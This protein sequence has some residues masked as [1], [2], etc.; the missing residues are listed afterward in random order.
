M[1][2]GKEIIVKDSIEVREEQ[3]LPELLL[4][5]YDETESIAAR[6]VIM[7][8]LVDLLPSNPSHRSA[9][10]TLLERIVT[11]GGAPGN[12]S[13][14]S[15]IHALEAAGPY[16]DEILRSY[17]ARNLAVDGPIRGHLNDRYGH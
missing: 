15:V 17:H 8:L 3:D 4:R 10:E 5:G 6:G 12:T 2:E 16:C 13:P 14:W 1:S 11:S 7:L 9:I